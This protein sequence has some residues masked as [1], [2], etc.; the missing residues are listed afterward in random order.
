MNWNREESRLNNGQ[1]IIDNAFY[2]Q[3]CEERLR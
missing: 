2:S 1:L 3:L